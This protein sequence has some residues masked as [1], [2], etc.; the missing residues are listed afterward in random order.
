MSKNH[1][2][3]G[4]IISGILLFWII[5]LAL[6][7]VAIVFLVISI[8]DVVHAAQ[9]NSLGTFDFTGLVWSAIGTVVL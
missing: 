4:A 7:V 2:G 1:A 3:P 9:T 6:K 5:W 8:L